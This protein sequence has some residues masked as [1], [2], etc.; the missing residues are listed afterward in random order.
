M[1]GEGV[2]IH[3]DNTQTDFVTKR[4]N[5]PKGNSVEHK[6]VDQRY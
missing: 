2:D 4:L 6:S 5:P 3:K 1:F